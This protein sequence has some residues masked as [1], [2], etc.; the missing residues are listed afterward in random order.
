MLPNHIVGVTE[1]GLRAN[2]TKEALTR[3]DRIHGATR[4]G[5]PALS[6]KE[7]ER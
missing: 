5:T 1:A 3:T 2:F 7:E 4:A 6:F